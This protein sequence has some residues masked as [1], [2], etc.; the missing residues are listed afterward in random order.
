VKASE[1]IRD[2]Q[3]VVEEHGDCVVNISTTAKPTEEQD[4][5]MAEPSYVVFEPSDDGNQV[6]IRDWPY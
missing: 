3:A 4:Y 6:S 5:V 2:L 1:L